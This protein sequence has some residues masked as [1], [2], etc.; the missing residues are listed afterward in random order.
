LLG[1]LDRHPE[2][3]QHD[4]SEPSSSEYSL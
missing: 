3:S 4:G 2:P 1:F